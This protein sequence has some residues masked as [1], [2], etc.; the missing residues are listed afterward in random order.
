M[1]IWRSYIRFWSHF[2]VRPTIVAA[3]P[4]RSVSVPFLLFLS[5]ILLSRNGFYLKFLPEDIRI[6]FVDL[7]LLSDNQFRLIRLR[8]VLAESKGP[9]Y[10]EGNLQSRQCCINIHAYGRDP[11]YLHNC[12]MHSLGCN[13]SIVLWSK[14]PRDIGPVTII[15]YVN[16]Y[17][18]MFMVCTIL[19]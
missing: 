8:I 6:L 5:L 1:T 13:C 18:C 12:A 14:W 10:R 11:Y 9:G 19:L 16:M 17:R 3:C 4:L 15:M 2:L 7:I